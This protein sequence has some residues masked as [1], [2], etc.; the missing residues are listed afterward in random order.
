MPFETQWQ[1][2]GRIVLIRYSGTL[3]LRDFV[4]YNAELIRYMD[5]GTYPVH[6]VADTVDLKGVIPQAVDIAKVLSY[7]QHKN[8]GWVHIFGANKL[9]RFLAAIVFQM[10]N[11]PVHFHADLDSALKFIAEVDQTAREFQH[12]AK[13]QTGKL[14]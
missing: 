12:R 10:V 2:Q 3:K 6:V 1:D 8:L 4:D 14:G 11:T 7:T 9:I 5:E 13:L